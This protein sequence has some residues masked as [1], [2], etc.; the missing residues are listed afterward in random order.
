MKIVKYLVLPGVALA[1]LTYTMG[2]G[3]STSLDKIRAAKYAETDPSVGN[4]PC[5][6]D[7][8]TPKDWVGEQRGNNRPEEWKGAIAPDTW[9]TQSSA[10]TGDQQVY[11]GTKPRHEVLPE[12][13]ANLP[14]SYRTG[15]YVS[16]GTSHGKKGKGKILKCND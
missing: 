2:S 7:G 8:K 15:D 13:S 3:C 10:T 14:S 12:W 11:A 6:P 9:T 16:N 1:L 5:K 4:P